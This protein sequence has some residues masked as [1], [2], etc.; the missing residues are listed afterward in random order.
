MKLVPVSVDHICGEIKRY[1]H[2]DMPAAV[3]RAAGS[4]PKIEGN[5]HKPVYGADH[6]EQLRQSLERELNVSIPYIHVKIKPEEINYLPDPD[7]VL[8]IPNKLV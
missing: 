8:E 2:N 4:L 7:W 6:L 5:P 1:K 3:I